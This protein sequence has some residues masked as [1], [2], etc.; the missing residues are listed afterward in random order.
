MMM[1]HVPEGGRLDGCPVEGLGSS[2]WDSQVQEEQLPGASQA[3]RQ[4]Q[5]PSWQ[6]L[7]TEDSWSTKRQG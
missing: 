2:G 7:G 5:G 3:H 1:E 4:L 6:P